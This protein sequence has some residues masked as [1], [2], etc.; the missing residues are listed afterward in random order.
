MSNINYND[1]EPVAP[2][3]TTNCKWQADAPVSDL[4][5]RNVSVYM[6]VFVGDT[7][8]SPVETPESGAVPARLRL[9]M[10]LRGGT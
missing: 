9:E 1:A 10:P 4:V 7:G 3:G 8:G 2:T 5:P 6:P